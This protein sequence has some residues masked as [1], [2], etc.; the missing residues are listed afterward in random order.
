MAKSVGALNILATRIKSL[1]LVFSLT[2]VI[3]GCQTTETDQTTIKTKEILD[4]QKAIV[5][6]ALDNGDA[7][8]AHQTLRKLINDF[9]NDASLQNLMGLT[10]LSMKNAARA[11]KHFQIAYKLDKQ[12]GSA[13]NLSS[14]LIEMGDY[15]KAISTIKGALEQKGEPYRFKER[16]LHNLAYAHLKQKKNVK[17][18]SFF[19]SAIEENP[20]FYPS[21]LEL[22][23]LHKQL[24]RPAL[25]MRSYREAMDY[26][27]ICLDPVSELTTL[28]VKAGKMGE[29]R[30]ILIKYNKVQG[31]TEADRKKANSLLNIVTAAGKPTNRK[32]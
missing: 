10:Q 16:F 17:A 8:L 4:S 20:S 23:R 26:C 5:H 3:G 12:P 24:G 15:D 28:Y 9:P 19:K 13:L 2:A 27:Q 31:V 7:K 6:N 25:A 18:E 29:A 1:A 32:L 21:H 14:A 30:D 11:V 22:A